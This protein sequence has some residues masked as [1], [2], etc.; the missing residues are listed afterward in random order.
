VTLC[1]SRIVFPTGDE[2]QRGEIGERLVSAHAVVGVFPMTQLKIEARRLVR[3]RVH[4]VELFMVGAVGALDMSV[5]FRRL[6]LTS[7]LELGGEL[8]AAVDL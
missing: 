3:V 7:A 2:F 6:R 8:A 5:Q 4:L 1:L